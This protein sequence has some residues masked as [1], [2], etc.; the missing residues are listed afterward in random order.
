MTMPPTSSLLL[1]PAGSTTSSRSGRVTGSSRQSSALRELQRR[2]APRTAASDRCEAIC[3]LLTL[4]EGGPVLVE[5]HHKLILRA[6][7]APRRVEVVALIPKGNGKT[8]V[9][10]GAAIDHLLTTPNAQEF[11]GASD[12][13]QADEMY[14]F[15]LHFA[16]CDEE[17]SEELLVRSGTREIRCTRDRG[18]ARVLASDTS[19]AGG[20]R[21]A[22]N[23]TLF[24][25]D[26]L[27]AHDNPHLYV[28]GRSGVFK[29]GGRMAVLST[30][31][32][33]PQSV[34]GKR[35]AQLLACEEE[36]GTILRDVSVGPDGT[37]HDDGEG[38]LTIAIVAS[39]RTVLLE[40]A[41]HGEDHPDGADDLDDPQVVKLA[42]PASFVS[43]DSIEDGREA[44]TP[45][46][47]ARYRANVWV[48]SDEPWLPGHAWE[49]CRED[50]AAIPAG[51]PV[52]LGVD[53]G[54]KKD[55]SAVVAL[56][57]R[58]DGRIVP[59]AHVF[60]PLGD[61]TALELATVEACIFEVAE[62]LSVRAVVY[63]KWS[64]ERSAQDLSDRG[65][66]M[67]ELP[68]SPERMT[69]A[70]QAIY[71]TI[72]GRQFAHGGDPVL[73]AHVNAGAIKQHE[74]AW[75]LVKGKAKRP[76]DALIA[77][78]LAL[79]ELDAADS[80]DGPLFEVLA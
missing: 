54:T 70:S 3:G 1:E 73:S 62:R 78:T 64:F 38:R 29:R 51:A 44:L 40:W 16:E 36:G 7:H 10:G 66:L 2:V 23:P 63:D 74:R 28:A 43:I 67:I 33:D 21:Q 27:H 26:E 65:L 17:I 45:T 60:T 57:Q 5:G 71:E 4:P 15:M 22:F 13:G 19:K 52:V 20:K 77:M 75:R 31:G 41:C 80:F 53:I 11:I 42:N 30:A 32:H 56:W 37:L 8:T 72:L 50:G 46:D 58:D 9:F 35:R 59:E 39:G 24:L 18:F 69:L 47:F 76:I 48:L 6:L 14:R 68:M 61:G 55:T 79:T 49:R 34:L 12:V 25:C